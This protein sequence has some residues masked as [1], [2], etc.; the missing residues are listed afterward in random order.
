MVR[1]R[2]QHVTCIG[3]ADA[4]TRVL[5]RAGGWKAPITQLRTRD[6]SHPRFSEGRRMESSHTSTKD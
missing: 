1:A 6:C 2:V 4:A 3:F 5:A